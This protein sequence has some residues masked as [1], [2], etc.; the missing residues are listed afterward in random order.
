ME[1][2]YEADPDLGFKYQNY[3]VCIKQLRALFLHI[4]LIYL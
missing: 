2:L 1:Y 4:L 3:A